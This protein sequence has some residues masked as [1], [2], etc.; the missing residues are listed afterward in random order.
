MITNILA[1]TP[2][3]V[4]YGYGPLGVGVVV[5]SYFGYKLF[6]IILGDRN[7]AFADR[8]AMVQDVLTK[9]LPAITQNTEYLQARQGLDRDLVDVIKESNKQLE[10]NTRAFQEIR[11]ILSRG[12]T[13]RTGGV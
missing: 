12:D 2:E 13:S 1:A 11:F 3:E 6:N 7:K 8:D 5:L 10:D 4:L 9:V